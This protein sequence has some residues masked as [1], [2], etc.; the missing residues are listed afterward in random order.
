MAAQPPL[1]ITRAGAVPF[2]KVAALLQDDNGGRAFIRGELCFVWDAGD[3][4]G[5]RLA[6]A[7]LGQWPAL[8]QDNSGGRPFI[9]GELCFVWDASDE[10]GR[11]L[12][13]VQLVRIKAASA[14][15]VAAAFAVSTVAL[16]RWR[17]VAG[18]SGAAGLAT[19]KPGPKGPSRLTDEMVLDIGRR[20]RRGATL[21]AVA[22]AVGV[23]VTTVRRALTAPAA[24]TREVQPQP[25]PQPQAGDDGLPL[26]PP[27]ADRDG[28]RAGARWGKL[29]HAEPVFTPAARVP[30][31]GQI[32]R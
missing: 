15:D 7:P 27:P 1:P 12:A 29:P 2:G 17:K 31:A 23:S 6:P 8:L 28:E 18:A 5:R 19:D 3:E 4:G 16:W 24:P 32:G 10:G 14:A 22:D 30:L 11:R 13:A 9:R 20:R 21:Q 25:Q 26:L